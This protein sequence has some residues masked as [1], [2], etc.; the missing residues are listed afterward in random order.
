M[1]LLLCLNF[2]TVA[3]AQFQSLLACAVRS[4]PPLFN[5]KF[6]VRSISCF[7]INATTIKIIL[8]TQFE[9]DGQQQ[10]LRFDHRT[11]LNLLRRLFLMSR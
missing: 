10:K 5:K 1:M 8:A 4:G 7:Y 2:F 6:L 3:L 11:C 9:T